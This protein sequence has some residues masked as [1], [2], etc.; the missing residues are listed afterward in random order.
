M[1]LGMCMQFN[2]SFCAHQHLIL[3]VSLHLRPGWRCSMCWLDPNNYWPKRQSSFPSFD[4]FFVV[5]RTN[6][7]GLCWICLIKSKPQKLHKKPQHCHR[8]QERTVYQAGFF[9]FWKKD[10]VGFFN[11]VKDLTWVCWKWEQMVSPPFPFER[12]S[13]FLYQIYS[14]CSSRPCLFLSLSVRSATDPSFKFKFKVVE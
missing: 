14:L 12:F 13:V 4:F 2:F 9:I 6:A 7:N 5:S 11:L 8:K 10:R 1:I 3:S